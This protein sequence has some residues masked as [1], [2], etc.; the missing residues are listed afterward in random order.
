MCGSRL[1]K[2]ALPFMI[3]THFYMTDIAL[4]NTIVL[5]LK[6]KKHTSFIVQRQIQ[7]T[8]CLMSITVIYFLNYH[9]FFKIRMSEVSTGH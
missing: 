5:S 4:I 1:L 8:Y 6:K 9:L 2:K 7:V 3:N